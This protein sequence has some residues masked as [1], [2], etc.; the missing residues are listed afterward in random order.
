MDRDFQIAAVSFLNTRPLIHGLEC[1]EGTSLVTAVPSELARLLDNA[2]A[3]VALVP[4]ID[5]QRSRMPWVILPKLCIGSDG[6]THTVQVYSRR[7]INSIRALHCDT[8]SH[9]SVALAKI[10]LLEKFNNSVELIPLD[11][12]NLEQVESVLLIG[13]K[14]ISTDTSRFNHSIDLGGEWK[15]LTGF[16]FVFAF[17]AAPADVDLANLPMLLSDQLDLGLHRLAD[18]VPG[19]AQEH[20]W[21]EKLAYEYLGNTINYE[22]G[23]RQIEGLRHFFKLARKHRLIERERPLQFYGS[24]PDS[25]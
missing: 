19:W 16:P 21:P 4:A 6:I 10:I 24:V 1:R 12:S 13:D 9:T 8:D 2:E 5:Y 15:A 7:P 17:W 23:L 22:M 3:D 11:R 18:L 20:C 14:V 25:L